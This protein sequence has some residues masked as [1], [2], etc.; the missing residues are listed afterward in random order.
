MRMR[1]LCLI[2]FQAILL[3][4]N[5][6]S[7]LAVLSSITDTPSYFG[8]NETDYQ[9]LLAFKTMITHDPRNVLSSW[10]D[11]LHFCQWE[12]VT[13]GHCTKPYVQRLQVL[14]LINNSFQGEIPANLSHCSNLKYFEVGNNN[15]SGS[16]PMEFA[17]LSKLVEFYAHKN[18]L[19][20]GIPPSIGNLSS[21]HY[22]S[23][24]Y[25]V[26]EGQIP[27]ALGQLRSIE[28]LALGG[29]KLSGLI[30]SSLY[31][32]SSMTTFSLGINELSGSLPIDLF[33]TLPNLQRL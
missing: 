23:L 16:I 20:R 9:A 8:G 11:S 32:L 10:N 1:L 12:G 5:V 3:L 29:N 18:Y 2:H 19:T 24:T 25:N 4:F 15:L 30:P 13:C 33:V 27:N 22:L 28:F 31:N 7:T 17:S 21:L 26:L 14:R 6:K